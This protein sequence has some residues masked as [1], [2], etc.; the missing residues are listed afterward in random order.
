MLKAVVVI[1]ADFVSMS[2]F[3]EQELNDTDRS[4]NPFYVTKV[5][6]SSNEQIYGVKTE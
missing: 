4:S 3:M 5:S 6:M 2:R 1:M